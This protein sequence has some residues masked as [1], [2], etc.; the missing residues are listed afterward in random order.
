M[1]L[2]KLLIQKMKKRIKNIVISLDNSDWDEAN[3]FLNR[4]SEELLKEVRKDY[5]KELR[6]DLEVGVRIV[7]GK[8]K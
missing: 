7:L 2:N 6:E 1:K 5:L 4:V 3:V 8:H